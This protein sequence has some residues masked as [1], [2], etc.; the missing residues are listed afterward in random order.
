MRVGGPNLKGGPSAADAERGTNDWLNL[1]PGT[2]TIDLWD[3]LHDAEV[4]SIRSNL[5]DRTVTLSCEIEWF[6]Y[7][8]ANSCSAADHSLIP[9]RPRTRDPCARTQC[10]GFLAPGGGAV[11]PVGT[12]YPSVIDAPSTSTSTMTW[13]AASGS[14]SAPRTDT[15]TSAPSTPLI[16][17]VYRLHFSSHDLYLVH[18]G[19]SRP[20]VLD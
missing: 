6:A 11:F 12:S 10:K 2:D 1:P 5:L 8:R 4:V 13:H 18:Q 17:R 14:P 16:S 15:E 3:C 9:P 20:R 19:N 7:R